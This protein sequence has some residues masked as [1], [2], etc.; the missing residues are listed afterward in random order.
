MTDYQ[1]RKKKSC[2][3]RCHLWSRPRT[4]QTTHVETLWGCY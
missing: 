2:R 3:Y 4:F 1:L